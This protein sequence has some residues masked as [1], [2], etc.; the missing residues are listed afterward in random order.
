MAIAK[1]YPINYKPNISKSITDNLGNL[2][3]VNAVKATFPKY[4]ITD[5]S[6]F[7][8]V[9]ISF[10]RSK[11]GYSSIDGSIYYISNGTMTT[12]FNTGGKYWDKSGMY[13][14]GDFSSDGWNK[15]GLNPGTVPS[16]LAYILT[17]KEE[18]TF[19]AGK[20]SGISE[21]NR[22]F[23]LNVLDMY[24]EVNVDTTIPS[25]SNLSINSRK[26]DNDILLTWVSSEQEKYRL[27]IVQN[28]VVLKTYNGYSEKSLLIPRNT[29][30][31]LYDVEFRLYVS[32]NYYGLDINSDPSTLSFTPEITEPT[33]TNISTIGNLWEKPITVNWRSE[34]QEKYQYECYYNN[35]L[36]KS[37]SGG[38]EKTF[39]IPANTFSGTLPS[40][41]RVRVARTYG[42]V[43][44]WSNWQESNITL[45]DI[46]ATISNLI[47]TG[48]EWEKPIQLTWQSE[49]QQKFKIEVRKNNLLVKTYTGT[50]A[51]SYTIPAEELTSGDHEFKVFVG[52]KDRFVNSQ[53]KTVN[54]KDVVPKAFELSLS[55]SNIDLQ[56]NA[57]WKSEN[58]QKFELEVWQSDARYLLKTGTTTKQ[59]AF[60]VSELKTGLNIFKLRV[61]FK[62]RWSDWVTLDQVLVETLPSIG[63]LE[64][65]GRIEDKDKPI[66]VYWESTNQSRWELDVN[67]NKF[68][69]KTEKEQTLSAGLLQTGRATIALKIY[70]DIAGK[71]KVATKT[72]EFIVKGI[73][74]APTITSGET[75]N[76]SRPLITWDT[77][78]QQAAQLKVE[79]NNGA[80]IYDTGWINGLVVSHKIKEYLNDGDYTV[81]VRVKNIY[82][83]TSAWSS[84]PITI[85]TVQK[86]RVT[87][88]VYDNGKYSTLKW[89]NVNNA[90]T[91][92]Y[93]FR[94]G[95]KIA[96]ISD[97]SYNDYTAQGDNIYYVKGVDNTDNFRDSNYV[98]YK[99]YFDFPVLSIKDYQKELYY[100]QN[101]TDIAINYN[102]M[103]SKAFYSGRKR[104]VVFTDIMS[105]KTVSIGIVEIDKENFSEIMKLI[106]RKEVL[107]Y[108][109]NRYKMYL[110]F[111]SLD[112][113]DNGRNEVYSLDGYEVDYTEEIEYD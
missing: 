39:V 107:L 20:I 89:D 104:P 61:A 52:Y 90:Y 1:I 68:N 16:K 84:K 13:Y 66:R 91:S 38:T 33:I 81:Y 72:V 41:V 74:P 70:L 19:L 8:N 106:E 22:E 54:L 63:I 5:Y 78:D 43:D 65:D 108:R 27:D 47:I 83:E 18:N 95:I 101:D 80:E 82:G 109:S 48:N 15:T 60:A 31:E 79:D 11:V 28:N 55:G 12:Y 34:L 6:K 49:D 59:V 9:K 75:Y 24:I 77:Q 96:N 73:P 103:S 88:K 92:Y 2:S 51:K 110:Y 40:S 93:V 87:L 7:S 76:N 112:L 42:G 14:T 105:D 29:I 25:S 71:Q 113:D 35:I 4:T 17:G 64:P 86:P 67:G 85:L 32:K 30:T 94:N 56:I 58:Q 69:G 3:T 111:D 44:Y 21:G 97:L 100:K 36:V 26:I 62:D 46:E 98:E 37:G 102:T 45:R 23:Y 10:N 53:T 50:T 99:P 57:S